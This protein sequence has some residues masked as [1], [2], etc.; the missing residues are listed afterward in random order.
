MG[1]QTWSDEFPIAASFQKNRT[2]PKMENHRIIHWDMQI[3]CAQ[4]INATDANIVKPEWEEAGIQ[5]ALKAAM[6]KQ[7]H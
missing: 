4:R 1:N 2:E 6:K 5:Q 7:K 3:L